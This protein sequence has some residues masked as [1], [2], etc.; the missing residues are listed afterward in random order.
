MPVYGEARASDTNISFPYEQALKAARD[1]HELAR[2][3]RARQLA[4]NTAAD[5]ARTDWSGPHRTL[6]DTKMT[7]ETTKS[8]DVAG[9]LEILAADFARAWSEAR[10][11][12]DRI[13]RARYVEQDI[14]EDNIVENAYE[15]F[16]GE[17]DYGPPP[18]NPPIPSPPHFTPTRDPL[19]REF[20]HR[21]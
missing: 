15:H 14:A 10:G 12:Q 17:T 20:E 21:R 5:T 2:L 6:F 16:M 1:L 19:H 4:R 8:G 7:D 3:V 9:H 18:E 13:N 11:Q